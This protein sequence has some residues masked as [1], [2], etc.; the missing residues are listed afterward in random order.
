MPERIEEEYKIEKPRRRASSIHDPYSRRNSLTQSSLELRKK[1]RSYQEPSRQPS[2]SSSEDDLAVKPCEDR[3]SG[4]TLID[5]QDKDAEKDPLS[6]LP[7]PCTCPYFGDPDKKPPRTNEV[8]II[9]TEEKPAFVRCSPG[10][11]TPIRNALKKKYSEGSNTTVTWES[12]SRRH[13]R[14]SSFSSGS[15]RTLLSRSSETSPSVRSKSSNL[16]RAA[17]LRTG[18]QDFKALEDAAQGVLLRYGSSPSMTRNLVVKGPHSRNSSIIS[19]TSSRHGRIIRLEQKATKVLGVVFFTFVILW[20]PFFVLNLVPSVC[21]ECER[22]IDKWVFDFVTWLGYASSMVN[23]IF[24][25]IFNKVFRQA[26]KKVLLCKYRKKRWK[27][28]N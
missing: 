12:P 22:N 28:N 13:R 27:L 11:D 18:K 25:T 2:S 3:K 20:A 21:S 10:E 23:P 14:G 4:Y 15:A 26:F 1:V 17:T 19:R 5:S 8:V 24:Y 9:T 7:P 6:L 16:R